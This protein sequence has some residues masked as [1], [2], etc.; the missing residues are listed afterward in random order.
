MPKNLIFLVIERAQFFYAMYNRYIM[1]LEEM[2][3][4]YMSYLSWV[5][6]GYFETIQN[7]DVVNVSTTERNEN[8]V[9]QVI[10]Y[11]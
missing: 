9:C 3:V 8:D 7:Y 2:N 11:V 10:F 6:T 1:I 5:Q 4:K